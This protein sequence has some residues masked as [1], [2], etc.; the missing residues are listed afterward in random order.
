MGGY[1]QIDSKR[2]TSSSCKLRFRLITRKKVLPV[3]EDTNSGQ[4]NARAFPPEYVTRS[5]RGRDYSSDS[6]SS[7]PEITDPVQERD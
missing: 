2:N 1:V 4:C 7:A 5:H 3:R 6:G